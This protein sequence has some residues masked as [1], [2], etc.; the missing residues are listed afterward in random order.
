MLRLMEAVTDTADSVAFCCCG[1]WQMRVVRAGKAA[2]HVVVTFTIVQEMSTTR[3]PL[4][5]RYFSIFYLFLL[6]VI[7]GKL[8]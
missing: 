8:L 7:V 1:R 5:G 6:G 4:C 2:K 3:G